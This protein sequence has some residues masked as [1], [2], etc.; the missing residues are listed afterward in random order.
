MSKYKGAI[1]GIHE[2]KGLV[3]SLEANEKITPISI[4]ED[5]TSNF[6]SSLFGKYY[7]VIEIFEK[8]CYLLLI[9]WYT[10]EFFLAF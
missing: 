1:F 5:A 9:C 3:A 8:V 2:T 6:E 10:F 7:F 4:D